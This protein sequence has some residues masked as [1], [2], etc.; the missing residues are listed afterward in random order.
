M[1]EKKESRNPEQ[2]L[3]KGIFAAFWAAG[4]SA[5]VWT[6]LLVMLSGSKGLGA[7]PV[8]VIAVSLFHAALI[9]MIHHSKQSKS[10]K[11]AVTALSILALE[12]S[13]AVYLVFPEAMQAQ[14][15]GVFVGA[16][17]VG[18]WVSLK[19]IWH[20]VRFARLNID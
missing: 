2:V 9:Y 11:F 13:L 19:G 20:L 16:V 10:I 18:L 1:S 8:V 5:L 3:F 7:L 14:G 4:L 15:G 12:F 6:V 17:L